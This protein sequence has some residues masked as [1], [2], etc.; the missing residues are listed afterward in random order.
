VSRLALAIVRDRLDLPPWGDTAR[1]A[2]EGLAIVHCPA[3]HDA[4]SPGIASLELFASKV[5]FLHSR[6]TVLPL[7]FGSICES[8]DE[9]QA[10][11]R[12]RQMEWRRLLDDV[13]QC[14]EMGMRILLKERQVVRNGTPI[15]PT[16]PTPASRPGLAYLAARQARIDRQETSQGEARR[17]STSIQE[18]L[19][20]LYRRCLVERS[21]AGREN[22][23]SLVFLVPRVH[24][25]AFDDAALQ[26]RNYDLGKILLSGPW[27]PYHFAIPPSTQSDSSLYQF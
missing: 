3:P 22:L 10:V 2:H 27:P 12:V 24:R 18:A 6:E 1:S 4:L 9:L 19:C 11:L 7:R 15:D 17:V 25:A 26:L 23:L 8:N 16:I 14:D 5:A 20:G 13:D 21:R